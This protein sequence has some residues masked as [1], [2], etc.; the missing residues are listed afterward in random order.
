MSLIDG[1]DGQDGIPPDIRVSVLK[2]RPHFNFYVYYGK[3]DQATGNISLFPDYYSTAI[4]WMLEVLIDLYCR[5][6][7]Y[8]SDVSATYG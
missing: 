6:L 2:A 5:S 4:A 1:K 7:K 8:K 3:W